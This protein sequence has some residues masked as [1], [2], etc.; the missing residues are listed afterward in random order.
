MIIT[1][2]DIVTC[3][4]I[5]FMSCLSVLAGVGGGA[6][7][8]SLI[9][10]MYKFEVTDV[11]PI[12]TTLIFASTFV[13]IIYF[14]RT[15]TK[16]T[17]PNYQILL[18]TIPFLACCS[19]IGTMLVKIIPSVITLILIIFVLL[20]A[21][22][23]S[24][25]KWKQLR[26]KEIELNV[27]TQKYD[28]IIQSDVTNKQVAIYLGTLTSIVLLEVCFSIGR[29]VVPICS[30]NYI[31]IC[32]GQAVFT[33]MI[34]IYV[35]RFLKSENKTKIDPN[36]I[37]DGIE[38]STINFLRFAL[39]G[40][41]TSIISSW[42]GTGG[43]TIINPILLHLDIKPS[44]VSTTGCNFIWLGMLASFLNFAIFNQIQ[45]FYAIMFSIPAIIGTC[46][47]LHLYKYVLYVIG[48]Q[49]HLVLILMLILV[50]SIIMLLINIILNVKLNVFR[51]VNICEN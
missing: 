5:A 47:G 43:G 41:I 36:I 49:S 45:W 40:C 21:F 23:K 2:I 27:S 37:H 48:K 16:E 19:F 18:M 12:S 20:I 17:A 15:A 30:T 34:G 31:L 14:L 7:Y 1:N 28:S 42:T 44:I 6:I 10:L 51:F 4:I 35:Y 46:C 39:L 38:L 11:I 25:T 50:I 29:K 26:A 33:C 32:V 24:I 22:Y 9:L 8:T 13:N 3:I